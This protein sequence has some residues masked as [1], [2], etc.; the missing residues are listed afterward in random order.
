MREEV[1]TAFL[2][3]SARAM[4]ERAAF[5]ALAALAEDSPATEIATKTGVDWE[6]KDGMRIDETEVPQPIVRAAFKMAVPEPGERSAD[7]AVF[8]DGSRAVV[9]LSAVDLADY[10]ALTEADRD[11]VA[12]SLQSAAA[13]RDRAALLAT[14]RSGASVST[15]DF[16]AE[17]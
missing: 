16:E 1:R 9:V 14:L 3:D 5:E 8:D 17:S 10:D 12:Q 13:S 4:A 11:A 6:R 2:D 7:V 15:I